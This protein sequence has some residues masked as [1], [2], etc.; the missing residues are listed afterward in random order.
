MFIFIYKNIFPLKVYDKDWH[1]KVAEVKIYFP[2]I[3]KIC[4]AILSTFGSNLVHA[5]HQRSF[6]CLHNMHSHNSGVE[7]YLS[8]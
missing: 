3:R 5:T 6:L 7:L 8:V 4:F 2:A 1:F